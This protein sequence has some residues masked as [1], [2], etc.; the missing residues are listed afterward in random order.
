MLDYRIRDAYESDL[1]NI[2]KHDSIMLG[3]TLGYDTIKE[4][5]NNVLMKYFVI[6]SK[7]S[8]DFIGAVS[9]WIDENKAQINNIYIIQKYQNKKLGKAFMDY[10]MKYFKSRN[11]DEVTL[12]VRKSNEIAI[13]MYESYGFE[14]VTLR[15]NYYSN[16]EDALFMYLRIGSD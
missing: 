3:E 12:E 11:I 13:K 6:E 9:L 10:V 5:L 1:L 8:K 7:K 2:V 16:G 4:Y 14:L 15:K